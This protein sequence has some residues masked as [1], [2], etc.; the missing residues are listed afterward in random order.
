M[1]CSA[2]SQTA[3]RARALA[4]EAGGG[5]TLTLALRQSGLEVLMGKKTQE[6]VAEQP[7][8]AQQTDVQPQ[9]E[10]LDGEA[11]TKKSRRKVTV[12]NVG[13]GEIV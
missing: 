4:R 8:P 11:V 10:A 2:C 13:E 9:P 1:A 3:A 12:T 7:L 6:V 5:Q